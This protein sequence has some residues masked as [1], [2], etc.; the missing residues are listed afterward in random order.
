[1]AYQRYSRKSSVE[2]AAG[3]SGSATSEAAYR[4]ADLNFDNTRFDIITNNNYVGAYQSD[5]NRP[6]GRRGFVNFVSEFRG[7][8]ITDYPAPEMRLLTACGFDETASG[9]GGSVVYSYALGNP[10][11][12]SNDPAG[13]LDPIDL[14]VNNDRLERV[15]TDCVGSVSFNWTAGQIPTMSFNFEGLP[16][17]A[18]YQSASPLINVTSGSAPAPVQN[19]SLTISGVA[20]GSIS[21]QVVQSINYDL[22]NNIDPRADVNGTYGYSA[23]I[24][25]GR[26]PDIT[27]MIEATDTGTVNWETAF[28][29]TEEELLVTFTHQSGGGKNK[30][31]AVTFDT[32]LSEHPTLSEVN[33]KLVYTLK[34]QQSIDSGATPLTFTFAAS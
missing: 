21:S 11:L 1:M 14:K 18:A 5:H 25:T 30:E 23:P 3:A 28:D 19:Y 29:T 13:V 22:N 9:S 4:V 8:L 33:G 10:H 2:W 31:C 20:L 24:I 16:S 7:S 15:F 6:G 26:D 32:Y 17:G 27:I 34:L 12:D